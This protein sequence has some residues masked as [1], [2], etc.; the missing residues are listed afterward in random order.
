MVRAAYLELP[1]LDGPALLNGRV[2]IGA[3]SPGF[4]DFLRNLG[5]VRHFLDQKVVPLPASLA[6]LL[7]ELGHSILETL[8]HEVLLL[9]L[10]LRVLEL[11]VQEVVLGL[12][13]LDLLLEFLVLPLFLDQV[14]LKRG[15]QIAL[16]LLVQLHL[17]TAAL[18]LGLE[19]DPPAL[20]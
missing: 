10:L 16:G 18:P 9:V 15:D 6:Q 3:L 5:G 19:T 14:L 7:L 17:P 13:D 12:E 1:V 11:R 8:K 4:V 2:H 20:L